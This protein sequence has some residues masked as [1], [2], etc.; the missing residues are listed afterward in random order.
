MVSSS[1]AVSKLRLEVSPRAA[2]QSQRTAGVAVMLSGCFK[3]LLLAG[4][5]LS[6]WSVVQEEQQE[7]SVSVGLIS[8]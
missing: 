1:A 3:E 4:R 6:S 2:G 5:R 8:E 7:R